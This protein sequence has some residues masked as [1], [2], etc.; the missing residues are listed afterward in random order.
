MKTIIFIIA[1][2]TALYGCS[3]DSEALPPPLPGTVM[4]DFVATPPSVKQWIIDDCENSE[5]R[6]DP[7]F[8][9]YTN[10][11]ILGTCS[12]ARLSPYLSSAGTIVGGSLELNTGPAGEFTLT[13]VVLPSHDFPLFTAIF[14]GR[15]AA[16]RETISGYFDSSEV[17][18]GT[19]T[20]RIYQVP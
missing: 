17:G 14:I 15:M 18:S 10:G 9:I 19:W 12:L 4:S 1:C 13:L 5:W 8:F 11:V 16:D 7:R 2:A 6:I 3:G 20:G